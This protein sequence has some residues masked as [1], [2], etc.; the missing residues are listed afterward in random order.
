MQK[1][2]KEWRKERKLTQRELS[3][4]T[5]INFDSIVRYDNQTRIPPVTRGLTIAAVLEVDPY[6]IKWE[7]AE[8]TE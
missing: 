1:T 2:M 3:E 4:K 5:G 8:V 7:K 6:D